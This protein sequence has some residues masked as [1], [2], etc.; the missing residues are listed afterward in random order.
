MTKKRN[1]HITISDREHGLPYSKGLMASQVMVSG[2][3]PYRA[4]QVA[5]QIEDRLIERR[6]DSVT[7]E[8]LQALAVRVL[9]EIAGDRYAKNFVRWQEVSKLDVPLVLLIG[10]AT[11]V[12]KSTIATQLAARL[13]IVRVIP[14]DA[15]REVMRGLFSRELMPTL[16]TSSFD[17]DSAL[18]Q[19]P[20]P[21]AD[22]VIVGFREQTSAVSVG[23]R[24]LIER[25]AVEGTSAIIE[26]AHVVPG[27]LDDRAYAERVLTIPLVVTVEDEELHQSHFVARTA[28][29]AARPFERYLKAFPN[30]RKVQK[31][32][33]RQALTHDWPV[34][35]SYNLDQTI[36]SIIDLVVERATARAAGTQTPPTPEPLVLEGGT[37]A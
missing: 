33:K 5:E 14:T 32:I 37:T 35:A 3:S 2:L 31:Y 23:V 25:A 12:G 30:I 22:Q 27:F 19:P 6:V 9:E 34:V 26:G 11:G 10:G 36:A 8:E 4:Y 1:T 20:P 24:S 29:A 21:P 7:S 18:R 17:A 16:Y 15:I 28:D 13:G